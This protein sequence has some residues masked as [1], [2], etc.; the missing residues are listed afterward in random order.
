MLLWE[1]TQE[2]EHHFEH[3][4][5]IKRTT[6]EHQTNNERTHTRMIKNDKNEENV[7]N[8]EEDILH[9][10]EFSSSYIYPVNSEE[11]E[12]NKISDKKDSEESGKSGMPIKISDNQGLA[13]T[14]ASQETLPPVL[15]A[16]AP[17]PAPPPTPKH[18]PVTKERMNEVYH[19]AKRNVETDFPLDWRTINKENQISKLTAIAI[20]LTTFYHAV[21]KH[22][23]HNLKTE[24]EKDIHFFFKQLEEISHWAVYRPTGRVFLQWIIWYLTGLPKNAKHPDGLYVTDCMKS[25]DK[26]YDWA[27]QNGIE[28]RDGNA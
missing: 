17:P 1:S 22:L 7:Y 8:E 23:G 4:V 3:Q 24:R 25:F 26:F 11:K 9:D 14:H 10:S 27:H 18:V 6:D 20:S 2:S 28:L 15:P 21:C 12:K 5:N 19:W 16:A 13:G